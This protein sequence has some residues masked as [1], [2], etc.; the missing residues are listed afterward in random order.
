M[1]KRYS[2]FGNQIT[3]LLPKNF[4]EQNTIIVDLEMIIKDDTKLIVIDTLTRLYRTTLDDKKTNYAV[5]RELNRQM[6]FLKGVAKHKDIAVIVLNQ[7]RAKMDEPHGIEP[8]ATSI[9][10]YWSNYVICLR[11]KQE[12]GTRLVERLSP[13]GDPSSIILYITPE[14]FAAE[15]AQEKQ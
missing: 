10:D 4:D 13:E 15:K 12:V 1:Q 8:V 3:L 6:G 11:A 14:G 7:V 5:H 2:E 9:M